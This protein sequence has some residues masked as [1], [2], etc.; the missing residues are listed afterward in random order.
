MNEEHNPVPWRLIPPEPGDKV[1]I[2]PEAGAELDYDDVDHD[3]QLANAEF[4][5]KA[6]NNHAADQEKIRKLV[7]ALEQIVKNHK[8]DVAQGQF[9]SSQDFQT[10][11]R[12][13]RHEAA[14]IAATAIKKARQ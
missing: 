1:L 12:T 14:N 8:D 13:G 6:C 3:E 11:V 4:I 5:V 7:E 10:G 2:I 9:T